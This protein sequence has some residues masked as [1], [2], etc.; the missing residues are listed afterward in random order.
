MCGEACRN[1]HD[2][3]QGT[4]SYV[5][6]FV[7]GENFSLLVTANITTGTPILFQEIPHMGYTES[8]DV[9]G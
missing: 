4:L 5:K 7:R 9:C 8:L 2:T 1:E 3:P 6:S